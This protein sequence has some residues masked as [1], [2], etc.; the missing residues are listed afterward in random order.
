MSGGTGE[1]ILRSVPTWHPWQ[2]METNKSQLLL[3]VSTRH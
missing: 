1:A 3:H 2:V